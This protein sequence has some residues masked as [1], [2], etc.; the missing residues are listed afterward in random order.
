MT[1]LPVAGPQAYAN[2]SSAIG[3]RLSGKHTFP[4]LRDAALRYERHNR[5]H[6]PALPKFQGKNRK[7]IA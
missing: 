4:R 5:Q 1:T 7:R 3:A 6:P 2:V